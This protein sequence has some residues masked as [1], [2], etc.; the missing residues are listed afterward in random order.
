MV[1]HS[2]QAR[3]R[4]IYFLKW[5]SY[6]RSYIA[7][8]TENLAFEA[9]QSGGYRAAKALVCLDFLLA[10]QALSQKG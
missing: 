6:G 2:A 4:I 3:I 8:K 10:G 7:E 1:R 9:V 5:F